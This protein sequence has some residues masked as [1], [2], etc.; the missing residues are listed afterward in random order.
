MDRKYDVLIPAVKAGNRLT[1]L[2]AGLEK[3]TR[4]PERIILADGTDGK[5]LSLPKPKTGIPIVITEK[6]APYPGSLYEAGLRE[7]V[8]PLVLFLSEDAVPEDPETAGL[9][10][11]K[12][13]DSS[14]GAAYG[15]GFRNQPD[16]DTAR[17][18]A[19]TFC[20]NLPEIRKKDIFTYG[21][22]LFKKKAVI[23]MYRTELLRRYRFD[24]DG[25][26]RPEYA[27]NAHLL[28]GGYKILYLRE[29]SVD[30]REKLAPVPT[31]REAFDYAA[32]LKLYYASFGI[33]FR[34]I[35][36][37]MGRA[38]RINA[39]KAARYL[40]THGG[41]LKVPKAYLILFTRT[42]GNY[43]GNHYQR[44]PMGA[45]RFFSGNRRFFS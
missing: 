7:C 26:T 8:S 5:L 35:R 23:A 10:L 29:A 43:L 12:M 39:R 18:F 2:I 45:V 37:S 41:I 15:Q 6:T 27:M 40:V 21:G 38:Y 14:A 28:Y 33:A 24:P 22:Q 42:A 16:T 3:Q 25:L 36:I 34:N 9:L 4:K 31:F 44:L 13:E 30:Y 17:A 32:A 20:E 1:R 11:E 19:M